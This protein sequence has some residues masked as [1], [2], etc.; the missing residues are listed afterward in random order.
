MPQIASIQWQVA[1][2]IGGQGVATLR[3]IRQDAA[4]ITGADCNA[5]AAAAHNIFAAAVA[6]TPVDVTW[7]CLTQVDIYDSITGAVA[8]PLTVNSVPAPVVGT[9]SGN[10]SAGTGARI[11]WKTSTL[12]GR[13]LM[14]GA[15]Y[16]IPL[17]GPGYTANGSVSSGIV[18]ALNGGAGAYLT[19]MTSA[20]LYPVIWHRPPK[21]TH[22]GGTTGIVYAAVTS[23]VPAGLRSRRS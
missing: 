12:Q 5:A 20:S 3:F 11:N 22:A 14:R 13:R 6:S 17:A 7:S 15:L 8:G 10:Y 1:G 2:D 23:T 4:S 21:G 16:I 9:A 19:A 18:T